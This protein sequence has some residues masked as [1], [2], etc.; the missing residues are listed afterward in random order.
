[1]NYFKTWK[2]I[3]LRPSDF[4]KRMPIN[5]G[6]IDPISFVVTNYII[7]VFIETLVRPR[8]LAL[9]GIHEL[10]HTVFSFIDVIETIIGGVIGLFILA[11]ILNIL[12]VNN[13]SFVRG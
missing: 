8:M 12:Y 9:I 2:E 10:R 3:V 13:K 1:M 5:G 11:L 6:Y 4:Y 7:S